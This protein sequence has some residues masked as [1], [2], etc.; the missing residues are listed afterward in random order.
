MVSGRALAVAFSSAASPLPPPPALLS[1]YPGVPVGA[2][3]S[4]YWAPA[5]AST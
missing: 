4:L 3:F 2:P 1:L 5:P